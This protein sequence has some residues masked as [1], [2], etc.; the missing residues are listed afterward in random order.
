VV[1]S[2]NSVFGFSITNDNEFFWRIVLAVK[3]RMKWAESGGPFIVLVLERRLST[4][5]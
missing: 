1:K 4:H 5:M 3:T 2:Y